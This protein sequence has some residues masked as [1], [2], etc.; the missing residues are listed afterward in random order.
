MTAYL[1]SIVNHTKKVK[2]VCSIDSIRY[3]C[4]QINSI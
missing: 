3:F 2:K 4:G 1:L